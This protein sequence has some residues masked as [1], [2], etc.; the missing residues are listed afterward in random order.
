MRA[1]ELSLDLAATRTETYAEPGALPAVRAA[2]LAEDLRRRDFAINAM[3]LGLKGDDLGHLYDPCGGLGDL[4]ERVVRVLHE[5]SFIDDPTRL[6]RAVRY[7]TRLGFSMDTDTERLAREAGAAGAL[8]TVSGARIR[9]E[10]MDLL[11]ELEAPAAV[12][13]LRELELDRGLA[14]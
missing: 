9:D 3:A 2:S 4:D 13:R 6:L 12:E 1:D 7:E 11:R 8:A 14:S 5:R 10:L